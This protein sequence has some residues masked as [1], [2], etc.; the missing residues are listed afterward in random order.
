TFEMKTYLHVLF[1]FMRM[2]SN[3][4]VV[5][6]CPEST[7]HT[8]AQERVVK[9]HVNRLLFWAYLYHDEVDHRYILPWKQKTDTFLSKILQH[10]RILQV[11]LAE[12]ASRRSPQQNRQSGK[13]GTCNFIF[14]N[15]M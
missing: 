1:S 5:N 7:H 10:E 8:A 3:S 4:K 6:P 14:S 11:L 15:V 12:A 2:P 13:Q 9:E